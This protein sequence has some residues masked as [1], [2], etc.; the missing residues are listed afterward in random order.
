MMISNSAACPLSACKKSGE[1]ARYENYLKAKAEEMAYLTL[2]ADMISHGENGCEHRLVRKVVRMAYGFKKL[3]DSIPKGNANYFWS[4]T[5]FGSESTY[6]R[7]KGGKY[8]IEPYMQQQ[9]LALVRKHGGNPSVGF[10]RYADE[11]VLVKP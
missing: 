11:T 4:K 1:C 8:P 10:D 7:Y 5:K 2:N 3:Y 6:Y 9:L